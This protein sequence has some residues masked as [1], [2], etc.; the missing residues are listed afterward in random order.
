MLASL[1]CEEGPAENAVSVI[2][3][4]R[5]E[6]TVVGDRNSLSRDNVDTETSHRDHGLAASP[7]RAYQAC[8][9]LSQVQSKRCLQ[10]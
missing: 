3:S 8:I 7:S 9:R 1:R 6:T 2:S 5:S 4:V 10:R